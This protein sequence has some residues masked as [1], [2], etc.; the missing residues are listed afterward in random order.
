MAY[1]IMTR[2]DAE[3]ALAVKDLTARGEHAGLVPNFPNTP[4]IF[5][6]LTGRLLL[7]LHESDDCR[8]TF[9]E[10]LRRDPQNIHAAR[11]W[12]PS[13]I[14]RIRRRL[15]YAEQAVN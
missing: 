3:F 4:N 7:E 5:T 12:P 8:C 11:N 1:R 14:R 15:A 2:G 9:Q 6:S 10:E 13:A